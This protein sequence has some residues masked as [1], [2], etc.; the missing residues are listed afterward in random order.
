MQHDAP[1]VP[2][3]RRIS[4]L[5]DEGLVKL[6]RVGEV[7]LEEVHL[8][9]RLPHQPPILAALDREAIFAQ[10]LRVVALLP[11]REPEIVVRELAALGDFRLGLR[12]QPVLGR[13]PLGAIALQREIRLGPRERR[14][15][16]NRAFGGRAG[17]LVAPHI[18]QHE[19]HQVVR[20]GVVRIERHGALERRERRLV[21]P[22]IVVDL[23]EIELHDGRVRLRLGGPQEP[24]RRHFQP[25]ARLLGEPE[26]DDRGD[27]VRLVR[28]Q[29]LEFRHRFLE[30]AEDRVG[31][32]QL[33]A[34]VALVGGL[35]QLFLQLGDATVVIA[36]VVIGDLEVALRDL[37]ARVELER[38]RELL[39]GLGNEA[40]LVVENAEIVVRA[41]IG[42]IDPAGKGPQDGDVTLR[43]RQVS[44]MASKMA[45][46]DARSGRSRKWPRSP[47][48]ASMLNSVSTQNTKSRSCP[49]LRY[50]V[51]RTAA[52]RSTTRLGTDGSSSMPMNSDRAFM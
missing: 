15:Q 1:L 7:A 50:V 2:E 19:R 39:D 25:A 21:Q 17:L 51:V 43:D 37:H 36:G 29:L 10:G 38:P 14:I 33:P 40:F 23:A 18:A 46:R 28:Q 47:S 3:L 30:G 41:R 12:A 42:G 4:S 48:W 45:L 20:V 24:L 49:K 27:V 32:A 34:R 26:L 52:D 44:R 6:E 8:R 5:V 9:H 35:P 16:L 13:L 11:E 22:A 31:A